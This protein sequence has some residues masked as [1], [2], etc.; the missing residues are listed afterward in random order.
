LADGQYNQLPAFATELVRR[1]VSVIH[2]FGVPSTVAAKMATTTIPIVFRIGA[3]PVEL[4][5]VA[6]LNRPGSNVT[7]VTGLAGEANVKLLELIT[8]IV[9]AAQ[10]VGA[11]V[12]P[13]EQNSSNLA[14]RAV[15]D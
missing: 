14:V 13:K 12:N 8:E 2:T 4:G 5:L 7:G 9:P 11:L 1:K 3:D 15:A 10:V 6:S